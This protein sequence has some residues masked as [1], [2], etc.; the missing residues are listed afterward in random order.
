MRNRKALTDRASHRDF[1]LFAG[2]F[3]TIDGYCTKG[4]V[5]LKK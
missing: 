3:D 5:C 2:L 4:N 1:V